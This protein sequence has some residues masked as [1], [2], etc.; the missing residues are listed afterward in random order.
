MSL[1]RRQLLTLPLALAGTR[2]VAPAVE[3]PL[4]DGQ[5]AGK[6]LLIEIG[7]NGFQALVGCI[8]TSNTSFGMLFHSDSAAY[9]EL[10]KDKR[11]A[12]CS[13]GVSQEVNQLVHTS[14]V[15]IVNL[16]A[17]TLSGQP[18]TAAIANKLGPSFDH[19]PTR[20]DISL[21]VP[22]LLR[23][24]LELDSKG[25]RIQLHTGGTPAGAGDFDLGAVRPFVLL[26]VFINRFGPF[27]FVLDTTA[28]K[29]LISP[30]LARQLR[31]TDE[32]AEVTAT[33]FSFHRFAA[34]AVNLKL[35]A[36]RQ[37]LSAKAGAVV[38]GVIGLD[39]IEHAWISLDFR[40]RKI[41][42]RRRA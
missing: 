4:I 2:A 12:N 7:V 5:E 3:I 1:N 31:L 24:T 36:I 34:S 17:Y 33:E 21:G 32:G 41:F 8:D 27:Y 9:M 10:I 37:S 25:R 29:S 42:A 16:G 38:D 35:Q 22:M 30:E 15:E 23:Y 18:P 40:N 20:V 13:T 39:L 28:P 19:L 14:K 26:D 11:Q 6:M